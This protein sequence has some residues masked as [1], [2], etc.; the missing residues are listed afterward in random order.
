M[1]AF[2]VRWRSARKFREYELFAD[3][4]IGACLVKALE[5]S[6]G[7]AVWQAG[8]L[9]KCPGCGDRT[10]RTEEFLEGLR[11]A[12]A[13]LRDAEAHHQNS[14]LPNLG[15][16]P[17]VRVKV[18]H[19]AALAWLENVAAQMLG[20]ERDRVYIKDEGTPCRYATETYIS[21]I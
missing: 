13:Y 7:M 21:R 10:L 3:E 5:T 9:W 19:S 17:G 2:F 6:G 12:E 4:A 18:M 20:C 8:T 11:Q 14:P 16:G 1:K 15:E